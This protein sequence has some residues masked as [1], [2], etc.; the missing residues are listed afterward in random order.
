MPVKPRGDHQIPWGWSYR[1]LWASM[2]AENWTLVLF[3]NSTCSQLRSHFYSPAGIF[4]KK[5]NCTSGAIGKTLQSH[6]WLRGWQGHHRYLYHQKSLHKQ[7]WAKSSAQSHL[8]PGCRNQVPSYDQKHPLLDHSI[9]TSVCYFLSISILDLN[10]RP[11]NPSLQ[12]K[13]KKWFP[14]KFLWY[15]LQYI[16]K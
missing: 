4:F 13:K 6:L 3:K 8:V 1:S 16:G 12:V 10:L 9:T 11:K 7:S 2:C 14:L 15:T 5:G